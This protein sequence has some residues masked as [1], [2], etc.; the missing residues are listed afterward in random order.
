MTMLSYEIS[1][2]RPALKKK[3]VRMGLEKE[4]PPGSD[5]DTHFTPTYDPWDQRFW[6]VPEGDLFRVI[7][8]GT[9]TVVTG[10]IE[11]FTH[12]G[13]RLTVGTELPADVVMTAT[14]LSMPAL[15]GITLV[16]DGAPVELSKTVRYRGAMFSG[17]PDLA[18]A[19]GYT[20]ASWTLKCELIRVYF[21][22]LLADMDRR[23]AAQVTPTWAEDTLP[24]VP[25]L[26]LRSGYVQRSIGDFP[27]QGETASWRVHQNYVR[28]RKMFA[29]GAHAYDGL[30]FRRRPPARIVAEAGEPPAEVLVGAGPPRWGEIPLTG[31]A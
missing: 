27:R 25:F 6:V 24:E 2:R 21:C 13:I 11:T 12:T 26:D 22:R 9:A 3:L 19:I 18:A 28:D 10:H 30:D 20:N 14:G 7:R 8:D 4:L 17:V 16:V 31:D 15:G 1:R 29:A 5:I 23:G